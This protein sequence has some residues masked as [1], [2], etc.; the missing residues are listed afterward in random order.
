MDF[1]G[2]YVKLHNYQELIPQELFCVIGGCRDLRLFHVELHEIYVSP[3][4]IDYAKVSQSPRL[5]VINFELPQ[6]FGLEARNPR[7][8]R[9]AGSQ[10]KGPSA[11]CLWPEGRNPKVGTPEASGKTGPLRGLWTDQSSYPAEV[12]KWKFS[13]FFS[14][15]VREIWLAACF[16]WSSAWI[17]IVDFRVDFH[18]QI[19]FALF[20]SLPTPQGLKIRHKIRLLP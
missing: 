15:K 12:R 8:S 2:G 14:A 10:G 17:L 19:F 11:G 3:D 7:S 1:G 5:Y 13:P 9:R 6:H 16:S 18:S 20:P 4:V